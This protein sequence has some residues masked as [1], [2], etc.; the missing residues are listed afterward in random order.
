MLLKALSQIYLFIKLFAKAG[1]Y[2][3]GILTTCC[4]NL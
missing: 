2:V 3:S 4:N 1:Q